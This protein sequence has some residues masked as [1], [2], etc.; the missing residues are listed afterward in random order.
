MKKDNLKP[1]PANSTNIVLSEVADKYPSICY[2]CRNARK[3]AANE[4]RD[5]GYVGCAEF[6]R[7]GHYDFIGKAKELAEGWVDLRARIFGDK[8][9]VITNLQLMTLEV[10]KCSSFETES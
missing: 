8:S 1:E 6:T 10:K 5:K 9:G 4:N 2:V 3:P 7:K